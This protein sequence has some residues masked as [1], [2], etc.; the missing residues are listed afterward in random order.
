MPSTITHTH[1]SLDTLKRVN[2]K[3]KELISK[4]LEDYKSFAQGMDILYFYH[5]CSHLCFSSA[6]F[7]FNLFSVVES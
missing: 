7:G 2:L 5:F 4:H 3:P 6:N 1:I